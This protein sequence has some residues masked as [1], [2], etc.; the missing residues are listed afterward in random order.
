MDTP[1]QKR[2][3]AEISLV[4]CIQKKGDGIKAALIERAH[5]DLPGSLHGDFED[6]IEALFPTR[7]SDTL[8][9]PA[10]QSL[11]SCLSTIQM[12]MEA[13]RKV[14]SDLAIGTE[15]MRGVHTGLLA[16][17]RSLIDN[18]ADAKHALDEIQ[19]AMNAVAKHAQVRQAHD[20]FE[21][22]MSKEAAKLFQTYQQCIQQ[23]NDADIEVL[24]SYSARMTV[25]VQD[26]AHTVCA[27]PNTHVRGI[28]VSV[29]S[30][31]LCEQDFVQLWTP[32]E[33]ASYANDAWR[34][35][36]AVAA[37]YEEVD[38][39]KRRRVR[40]ATPVQLEER[41]QMP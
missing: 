31:V 32:K 9:L 2:R 10:L 12:C 17:L 18:D 14:H 29:L 37:M 23:E 34:E 33:M 19:R 41:Q 6:L 5:A 7:D 13:H 35:M 20:D 25:Y 16:L 26:I 38:R 8:G 1:G 30:D 36:S 15:R 4:E 28:T 11:E 27:N 24:R 3:H 21:G 22:R 39:I 40:G